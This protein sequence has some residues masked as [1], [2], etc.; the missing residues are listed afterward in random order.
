MPSYFC[1]AWL[2]ALTGFQVQVVGGLVHDQDVG[3]LQHELAEEQPGGLAAGERVGLLHALF[4]AEE[5]LAEDAADVFLGGLG[6]EGS[7]HSSTVVPF[8]MEAV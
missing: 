5:H 7:S 2:R 4:A 6:V 1:R 8:G 3:L